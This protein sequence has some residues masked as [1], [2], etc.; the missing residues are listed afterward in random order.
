MLMPVNQGF[1]EIIN[2]FILKII[3][4]VKKYNEIF[5]V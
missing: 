5:V 3:D 1:F 2:S 4:F